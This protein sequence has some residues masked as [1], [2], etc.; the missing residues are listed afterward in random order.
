L[1]VLLGIIWAVETRK[2][3]KTL[4]REDQLTQQSLDRFF[5][6]VDRLEARLFGPVAD[7]PVG[8]LPAG[9]AVEIPAGEPRRWTTVF[10]WPRDRLTDP[11]S[12]R[13]AEMFRASPALQ[14]LLA[15]TIVQ[16][17]IADE[18]NP[19]WRE[20]YARYY[21][22]SVPQFWLLR[23]TDDPSAAQ[24]VY[25]ADARALP[26][27]ADQLAGTLR[28][29]IHR[30]CPLKPKPTPEPAPVATPPV[31]VEVQVPE[32]T[33]TIEEPESQGSLWWLVPVGIAGLAI[34]IL[35]AWAKSRLP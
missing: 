22:G 6:T 24:V 15:Q 19:L 18:S 31:S 28:D 3:I 12:A 9:E 25:R 27:N 26:R 13:M 7:Q 5:G 21:A 4:Q 10:V 23:P 16:Q 17:Q 29:A 34:G 2:E 35:L 30:I 20:K 8:D 33:P 1:V 32:V 14:N 11:A